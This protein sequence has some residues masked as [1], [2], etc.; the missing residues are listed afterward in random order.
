[1]VPAGDDRAR[2]RQALIDLSYERGFANLGLA[3]LLAAADV[4]EQAFHRHYT[5]LEDCFF[6]V[7]SGELERFRRETAAA[8]ADYASWRD[9]LRATAYALYRFLAADER[10]RWLTAVEVRAASERSQLLIGEEVEALFALIDEGRKERPE[11]S[12]TLTRATAETLG[13]GIFNQV[14]VAAGQKGPMPP[15]EEIVPSLMY[16]AVLPYLGEEA[17]LEE[18]SIPPPERM[19]K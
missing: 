16:M 14:Y 2:I 11:L 13:G 4:D 1:M 19:A 5:D 7:Y 18:L 15:E 8:R 3:E 10:V 12:E 9:R 6:H 17:A